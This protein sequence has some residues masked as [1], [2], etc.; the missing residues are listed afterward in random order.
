[1]IG[2]LFRV[3]AALLLAAALGTLARALVGQWRERRERR[4]LQD[5]I[6]KRFR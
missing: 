5:R 2:A 1:M 4:G 3:L 6:K